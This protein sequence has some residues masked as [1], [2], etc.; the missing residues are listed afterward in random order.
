[1]KKLTIKTP[2]LLKNIGYSTVSVLF[3]RL[4]TALVLFVV[5]KLLGKAATGSYDLGMTYY[6]M[7]SI[8]AAW[9]LGALLVRET[10][11][12][13]E[14]FPHYFSNYLIIRFLIRLLVSF[15]VI[16]LG[17][18]LPNYEC[19]TRWSIT[20][21]ALCIPLTATSSL[22]QS[23]F[24]VFE[25]LKLTCL[26]SILATAFRILG[27]Y[28]IISKMI[29]PLL[30][31]AWFQLVVFAFILAVYVAITC[32]YLSRWQAKLDRTFITEQ[33]IE[34]VPFFLYAA[35]MTLE[36]RVDVILISLFM[37]E[38]SVG[39]YAV[40]TMLLWVAYLVPEGL[41]NSVLPALAR[42]RSVSTDLLAQKFRLIVKYCLLITVPLAVGGFFLSK[43]LVNFLYKG[44]YLPVIR[45][46]QITIWCHLLCFD[47]PVFAYIDNSKKEKTVVVLALISLVVTV[48]LNLLFLPSM[49]LK[50]AAIVKLLTTYILLL[51]LVL[52]VGREKIRL[53]LKKD[54]LFLLLAGL[55]MIFVIYLTASLWIGI[56]LGLGLIAYILM[57]IRSP[58][59]S[60]KEGLETFGIS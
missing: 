14:K 46:L 5:S 34:A 17:W 22:F 21:L 24:F 8:I 55:I 26:I 30:K 36:N 56:R 48:G 38:D 40:M 16:L 11:A 32:R 4:G 39:T 25:K 49:G 13:R 51:G 29:N 50:G 35:I 42:Y 45:L 37:K 58:I 33:V 60:F 19:V 6:S 10:A 2:L 53:S 7:G 23:A 57:L 27:T 43:H 52:A 41:R 20:I 54:L 15:F 18:T 1:M 9:G 59:F 28:L 47:Y 44:Q 3:D 12:R 31:V